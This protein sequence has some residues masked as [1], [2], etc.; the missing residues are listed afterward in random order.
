[1]DRDMRTP[2]TFP[3]GDL[4]LAATLDSA[5]GST[6]LL[7]V[8]GG[9]QIRIGPHRSFAQLATTVAANGFPVFRF[10]RR[11]IGDSEGDDPGFAR[12]GPDL[13]AAVAAFRRHC[14]QLR[15]IVGFGLCDGATALALHH[16]A[17]G[18]DALLLA[19][20]WVIEPQAGLPPAAAIRRHYIERLTTRR[21]WSH[22]LRGFDWRKAARGMRAA[23]AP[24]SAG[25]A[26]Q[27]ARAL[28]LSRAPV[29]ILLASG[30]ATAIAFEHEF[31]KRPFAPLRNTGRVTIATLDSGS[32][33]F[34]ARDE[35]EWLART[36]IGALEGLDAT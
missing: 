21:G 19:N 9:T 27:A 25:L 7:M 13:E 33:S 1:M 35:A 23:A 28:T 2:L 5:P 26:D 24:A 3:L 18:L 15:R 16:R 30:D 29:H 36:V 20:P 17:A 34:A 4:S 22:L 31:R 10:D 11:G 12:S 32:H 14:P 8:T 6:G